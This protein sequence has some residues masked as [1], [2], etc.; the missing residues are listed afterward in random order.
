MQL[1]A[2]R[3]KF[4]IAKRNETV[5]S[6]AEKLGCRRQELS[7]VINGAPGRHYPDLRRRL[8]RFLSLPT[9]SKL[10]YYASKRQPQQQ[11]KEAA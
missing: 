1:T 8:A 7:F 11:M 5:S 6:L 3:L 2:A 4:E 9:T 10:L